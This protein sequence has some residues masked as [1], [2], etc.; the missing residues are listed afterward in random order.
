M[1]RRAVRTK[2]KAKR[3]PSAQ[4]RWSEQREHLLQAAQ[5]AI[6]RSGPQI[7]MDDIA[8][9]AGITKPIVY[10]HFGDRRGL[11][12]ALRDR[13]FGGSLAP[14]TGDPER[15]RA[16]ARERIAA[17]FPVVADVEQLRRLIVGWA[18]SFQMFVEMNRNLYRFLRAEGVVDS[19]LEDRAKGIE[20]PLATSLASSL[21]GVFDGRVDDRTAMIWA[22]AVRGMVR[23]LVDWASARP[24]YDRFELERQFDVLARALL[25]GLARTPEPRSAARA[26][27][28]ARVAPRRPRAPRRK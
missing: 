28:R 6:H 11:A 25:D 23:G 2:T 27:P 15:D 8:A 7:S 18:M 14:E 3:A 20:D 17:Y 1:K 22:Q 10:R 24:E 5:R 21:R 12:L 4:A 13:A 19:A 16:A 9:E 26:T